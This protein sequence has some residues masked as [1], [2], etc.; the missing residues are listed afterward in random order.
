MI[1]AHQLHLE[2]N[3]HELHIFQNPCRSDADRAS[4]LD[5]RFD[6]QLDLKGLRKSRLLTTYEDGSGTESAARH[7]ITIAHGDPNESRNGS[8]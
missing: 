6:R 7:E 1:A 8:G 2:V 3:N 4:S 5:P